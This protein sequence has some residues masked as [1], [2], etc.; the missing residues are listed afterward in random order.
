MSISADLPAPHR[1][2]VEATGAV[3][4]DTPPVHGVVVQTLAAGCAG[5]GFYLRR[6]EERF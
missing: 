3:I 2:S 5:A 1:E 4:R 6:D